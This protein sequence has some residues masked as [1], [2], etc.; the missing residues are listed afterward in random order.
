MKVIFLDIDGVLNSDEYL[1]KVKNSDIQGIERDIDVEKVK[2]LK[3]AIDETGARVVLSSSWRWYKE[4]REK[5]KEQLQKHNLKF[6]DITPTRTDKTLKREEEI[7]IWLD[8]HPE[9][10][11][12]VILDDEKISCESMKKHH[13][14]TTFSR[15]LTIESAQTAIEILNRS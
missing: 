4:S 5:I 9:V 14:K 2:L 6:I 1:D 7:Q 12:Y 13:V 10:V 11:N 3:R 15:G 8:S